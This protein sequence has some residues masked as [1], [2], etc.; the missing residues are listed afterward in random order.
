[1]AR[2]GRKSAQQV[3]GK[4]QANL[5]AATKAMQDG[6]AGVTT[7]P[8]QL[9]AAA[10]PAY[11]AGVQQAVASG[12]MAARLNAV[13]VQQ[14]R[15]AYVSKGIPRVATGATAAAG[16]ATQAFSTLLDR[17]YAVRDQVNSQIPRGGIAQ[18]GQRSLLFQQLMH[19]AYSQG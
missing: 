4:W 3:V 13:T 18:N 17:V 19:Q 12:K 6:A 16:K 10:L 5:S 11:L 15:D 7:S 2:Q 9:A 14:W 8:T 1:M